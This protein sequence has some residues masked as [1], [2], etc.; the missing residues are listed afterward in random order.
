MNITTPRPLP[1]ATDKAALEAIAASLVQ[2]CPGLHDAAQ[3]VAR[4]LLQDQ[5]LPE[6]D[7]DRVYFHRFKTAQSSTRSFTGW[8]H[9]LEKP[10][11]STTLTQLVIHRFRAT[12]QDN[13]DLLD[14]YGGFYSEGPDAENFSERNEVRLHGSEVLKA[15]WS[16]DF[17]AHYRDEL[18]SFW[19]SHADNFRTL[20]KCNFLIQAVQ[21]LER[22]YISHSDF[23]WLTGSVIGELSWPVTLN[24]LQTAHTTKATS[25][26]SMLTA[27]WQLNCYASSPPTAGRS[28]M[29][30]ATP[31]RSSS[32][33]RLQRCTGGCSNR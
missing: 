1:N 12:D 21:A 31:K 7:P 30:Q 19:D 2:A 13:A 4:Q 5:G 32:R 6:H 29:C 11:E 26:P 23:Q 33:R 16:L 18:S 14:L 17:S 27:L 28:C 22:E 8:E 3:Q 24:M 15:F 10:Y 20:A 9:S 25:V